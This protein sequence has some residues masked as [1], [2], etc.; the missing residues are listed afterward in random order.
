[1]IRMKRP[2]S[3]ISFNASRIQIS[4]QF[5]AVYEGVNELESSACSPL[6]AVM[7]GGD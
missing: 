7:Q 1:M 4:R 5:W 6:L 3:G 2:R